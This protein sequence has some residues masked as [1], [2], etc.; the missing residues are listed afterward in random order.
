MED[1]QFLGAFAPYG[2]NKNPNDRHKMVIDEDAAKVVKKIFDLY[3]NNS[4]SN[5]I[6]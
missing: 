4:L 3:V 6:R 2:Y 1:G 5:L